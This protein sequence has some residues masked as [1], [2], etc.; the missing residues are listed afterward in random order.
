[1]R[2]ERE[3]VRRCIGHR[4]AHVDCAD[5][6]AIDAHGRDRARAVLEGRRKVLR[7]DHGDGPC[8]DEGGGLRATN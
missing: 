5:H 2:H 7:P 4:S 1:M 8:R 3:A 6:L